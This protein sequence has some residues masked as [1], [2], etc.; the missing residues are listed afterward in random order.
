[1]IQCAN[2]L[3]CAD[4]NQTIKVVYEWMIEPFIWCLFKLRHV[5]PAVKDNGHTVDRYCRSERATQQQTSSAAPRGS[6][7]SSDYPPTISA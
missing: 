4:S 7:A 2:E 1:M 6:T 5:V 3:G